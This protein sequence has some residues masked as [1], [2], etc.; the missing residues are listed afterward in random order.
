MGQRN[1]GCE[2]IFF[3]P[4][5]RALRVVEQV[6]QEAVQPC[7]GLALAGRQVPNK[8]APSLPS[9][10]GWGRENNGRLVGR[11]K[12]REITQQLPSWAKQTRLGEKLV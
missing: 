6:A 7:G 11:D 10:A 12:D 1:P 2:G 9:S 8:A 5:T 4:T 3:P